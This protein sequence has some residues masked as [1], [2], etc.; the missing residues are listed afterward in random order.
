M[1]LLPAA[2]RYL[3]LCLLCLSMV[4]IIGTWLELNRDYTLQP[5]S[6]GSQPDA[7]TRTLTQEDKSTDLPPVTDFASIVE[8]PLFMG[9]RR[10]ASDD[11]GETVE[12]GPV[13]PVPG[14][15]LSTDLVLSAIVLDGDKAIA[16]IQSGTDRKVHRLETGDTIDGWAVKE[17]H[18]R[19]IALVRGSETR[20]LELQVKKSPAAGKT[21]QRRQRIQPL[22]NNRS[23]SGRQADRVENNGQPATPTPP[24]RREP[25][26]AQ[27]SNQENS[28]QTTQ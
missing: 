15:G 16:L 13:L 18:D 4:F 20:D 2:T 12:A 27:D 22:A 1:R 8:R 11:N 19:K 25:A 5:A 23:L 10:P 9:D 7:N 6:P 21:P 28:S 3:Q 17:I 24:V 14:T 26:G